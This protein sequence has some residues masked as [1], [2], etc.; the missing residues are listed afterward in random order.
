[1][2]EQAAGKWSELVTA[3]SEVAE[4]FLA[5]HPSL[6]FAWKD[7]SEKLRRT[8]TIFKRAESE[9]DVGVC[10]ET[11]GLYPLAGD[12]HGAPW[13]ISTPKTTPSILARDCIGWVHFALTPAARLRVKTSNGLPYKWLFEY[14]EAS[15]WKIDFETD[16]I[17]FNYFGKR[18]EMLFQ[19]HHL[20]I[21]EPEHKTG[22]YA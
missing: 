16:L 9:F 17:F 12:W 14:Q 6:Q 10:C 20:P 18:G 7:E 1:M 3:F 22:R 2:P 11:Y 21:P 19:N 13:D 8:L 4:K 5:D 15:N